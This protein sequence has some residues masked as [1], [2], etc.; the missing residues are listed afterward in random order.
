MVP[1]VCD[2]IMRGTEPLSL[3]RQIFFF[4]RVVFAI[5]M[6]SFQDKVSTI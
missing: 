1:K 3:L 4:L 2:K 6:T 5:Q